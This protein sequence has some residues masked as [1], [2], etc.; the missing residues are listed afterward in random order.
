MLSKSIVIIHHER[1][2][3]FPELCWIAY[4]K[5][6][7]P[8]Y[9]KSPL[10]RNTI[11]LKCSSSSSKLNDNVMTDRPSIVSIRTDRLWGP[12]LTTI[13]IRSWTCVITF[14]C[15]RLV[16]LISR[17]QLPASKLITYAGSICLSLAANS[18]LQQ[19]IGEPNIDFSY[20]IHIL[21]TIFSA[22]V[23]K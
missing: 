23:N 22:G 12:L 1:N 13:T 6:P 2:F 11:L 7:C 15:G 10:V 5:R 17:I 16:C 21:L 19:I 8:L 9:R 3:T 14:F 18:K 20:R 4:R